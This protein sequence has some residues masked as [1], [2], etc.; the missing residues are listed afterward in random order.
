MIVVLARRWS[1][2]TSDHNRQQAKTTIK[3]RPREVRAVP[4]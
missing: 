4:G 3:V 2:S 1:R